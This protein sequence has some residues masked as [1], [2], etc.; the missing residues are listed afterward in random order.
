MQGVFEALEKEIVPVVYVD[1]E[2]WELGVGVANGRVLDSTVFA[3]YIGRSILS[4]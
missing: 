4:T 3:S 1:R 2:L